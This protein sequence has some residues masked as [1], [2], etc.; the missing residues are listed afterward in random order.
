[1]SWHYFLFSLRDL[2]KWLFLKFLVPLSTKDCHLLLSGPKIEF[3][4]YLKIITTTV[5][6]HAPML[7]SKDCCRW[8]KMGILAAP[9]DD[10]AQ[11]SGGDLVWLRTQTLALD[12]ALG[13]EFSM[14]T[15]GC[16]VAGSVGD[17]NTRLI[18]KAGQPCRILAAIWI[19]RVGRGREGRQT[20][21]CKGPCEGNRWWPPRPGSRFHVHKG[22]V[23]AAQLL[24]IRNAFSR[25][26]MSSGS[27]SL[28]LSSLTGLPTVL[29]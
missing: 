4:E 5:L 24:E 8:C 7:F 25:E 18:A 1:M 28:Y 12:T 29:W 6:F 19:W 21:D 16:I 15:Q 22:Q 27:P 13:K 23:W 2:N 10:R 14:C 20:R 3:R 17:A 11:G 9:G 26:W